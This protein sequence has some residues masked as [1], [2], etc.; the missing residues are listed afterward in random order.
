VLI[1]LVIV[2]T[3]LIADSTTAHAGTNQ[4]TRD[5]V[6]T[7]A[8]SVITNR[9]AT[10][11][12]TAPDEVSAGSMFDVDFLVEID[13][14]AVS[15]LS[16]FDF[17]VRS[18]WTIVGGATPSGSLSLATAGQDYS[19]GSTIVYDTLTQSF[20]ATGSP[21]DSISYLLDDVDYVFTFTDG[22]EL[23]TADCVFAG[24][25]VDLGSTLITAATETCGGQPV[26]I[27]G[28][29]G[30]DLLVGTAAPDVIAGGAGNDVVLGLGG[31]DVVC[32]DAGND[33]LFGGGGA[34]SLD[35]G[36]GFNIAV[37]GAGPDTCT[38]A[39]AFL[40]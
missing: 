37:G 35:G 18:Q 30:A 5:L 20:A 32:G 16:I 25:Q 12:V 24:P 1:G 23:V 33:V 22:G 8:P 6:C 9:V 31:A 10:V 27:S 2:S 11:T 39:I 40:C 15:P 26:T 38:N 29:S 21:G 28:T 13:L 34:D 4:I 7:F 3:L 14:P 19:L 36:A 17:S